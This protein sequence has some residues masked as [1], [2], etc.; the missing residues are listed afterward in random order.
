MEPQWNPVPT[1][2][3]TSQ[4]VDHVRPPSSGRLEIWDTVEPGFGLRISSS[5]AKSYCVTYRFDGRKV[6]QTIGK[7]GPALPLS[8]A[9]KRAA[10]ARELANEGR[11]PRKINLALSGDALEADARQKAA[12]P[13]GFTM[14]DLV[15]RYIKHYGATHWRPRTR[16]EAERVLLSEILPA[17]GPETRPVD[18]VRADIAAMVAAKAASAPYMAN[19]LRTYTAMMFNWAVKQGEGGLTVSPAIGLAS[20]TK[21]TRRPRVLKD[22]ELTAIWKA[23]D[24]LPPV[25]RDYF[26]ILALTGQRRAQTAGMSRN[27]V[28]LPRALWSVPA[29]DMK[30]G[31]NHLVP[32]SHM[33]VSILS[34]MPEI[35]GTDLFFTTNGKTPVSGFSKAKA[36]LVEASGVT[37]WRIHDI[38][39][40][41]ATGISRLGFPRFI[42]ERVLDHADNSVTAIYDVHDYEAERRAALTGHAEGIARLLAGQTY[43][44]PLTVSPAQFRAA[45]AMTGEGRAALASRAGVSLDIIKAIEAGQDASTADRAKVKAAMEAAGVVFLPDGVRLKTGD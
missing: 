8:E 34:E 14:A 20:A 13:S 16:Q 29:A 39:R 10:R 32:L 33:A 45:R 6:R 3:L 37:D 19:R 42:V 36:A 25:F 30:A 12:A 23:C 41:V 17:L 27:D 43:E 28:D 9:R 4:T 24:V 15:D 11:D 31:R 5:G 18:V 22:A 38:R 35:V 44:P 1:K 7:P 26:R 2:R 40:T 21:E